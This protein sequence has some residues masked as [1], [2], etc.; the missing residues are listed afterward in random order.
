MKAK[1]NQECIHVGVDNVEGDK[2]SFWRQISPLQYNLINL[3]YFM[4]DFGITPEKLS[5]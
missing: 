2:V 4:P 3:S 5:N 1:N